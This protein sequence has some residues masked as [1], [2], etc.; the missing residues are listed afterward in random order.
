MEIWNRNST[1]TIL[2]VLESDL[3]K[4]QNEINCAKRDLDKASNRLAFC[5]SAIHHLKLKQDK[6]IKE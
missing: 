6:D 2:K 4:A 5:L 1:A 3:A